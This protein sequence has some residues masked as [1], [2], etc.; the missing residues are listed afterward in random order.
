MSKRRR[1]ALASIGIVVLLVGGAAL[2]FYLALH[3][4]PRFY[5]EAGKPDA[6]ARKSGSDEMLRRS[7]ELASDAN[8][9]GRWQAVFTA[10]QINGWLAVDLVENHPT[11]LP[12]ELHDPRVAIYDGQIIVG[13]HYEGRVSTV[14][15]LEADAS[16]QG[17]NVIAIRI[18]RA[19][20]GA[21]PLPL[22]KL[23]PQAV[24]A[25]ENAGCT[26]ELRQA[27]ADPVLLIT[28]HP[29]T[30][31]GRTLVLETLTLREGQ[32]EVAGETK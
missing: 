6:M 10:E 30:R 29:Q 7:A 11:L 20:A 13:C 23:M 12:P 4:V 31:H 19:R 24:S 5:E 25:L 26:V 3:H 9:R 17:P 8:R 27:S 18:R 15:S 2:W 14:A 16:L 21:V 1:I 28:L 32:L 22:D